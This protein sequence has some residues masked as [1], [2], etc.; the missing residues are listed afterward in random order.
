[1]DE[2]LTP[3]TRLQTK[4]LF[5][6]AIKPQDSQLRLPEFSV[7]GDGIASVPQNFL[8]IRLI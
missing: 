5:V 7:L 2:L 8:I 6:S 1:M 4:T 3:Q